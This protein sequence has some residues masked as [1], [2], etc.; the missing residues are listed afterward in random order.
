MI[1][2]LTVLFAI[3]MTS[4]ALLA[5]C[6]NGSTSLPSA[7][8]TRPGTIGGFTV[9]VGPYV[10]SGAVTDAVGPIAGAN[11]NAWVIT[12]GVSYSYMYVH[13][14]LLTDGAG[15]YRMTDLPGGANLWFQ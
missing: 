12:P 1:P 7:P 14:P 15:R 11:V 10:V 5:G 8:T 13:G 6:S 4:I 3:G 9:P 2:P